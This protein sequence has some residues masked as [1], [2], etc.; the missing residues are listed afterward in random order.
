M[1]RIRLDYSY[2]IY[3]ED[4]L[5]QF[6]SKLLGFFT[7]QPGGILFGIFLFAGV[8]NVMMEV[9]DALGMSNDAGTFLA[10]VV[11]VGALVGEY[12]ALKKIKQAGF[13][14][15]T[16]KYIQRL[17]AKRTKKPEEFVRAMAEIQKMQKS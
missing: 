3:P 2:R 13:D 14:F 16:K 10:F 8:G 12:F 15:L 9:A 11:A 4:G 7:G 5:M 1:A 6:L 17:E